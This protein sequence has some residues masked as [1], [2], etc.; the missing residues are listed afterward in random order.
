MRDRS[1]IARNISSLFLY[2]TCLLWPRTTGTFIP[3]SEGLN[4]ISSSE[5]WRMDD[6]CRCKAWRDFYRTAHPTR[7][8][9]RH[10]LE[11]TEQ[12]QALAASSYKVLRTLYSLSMLSPTPG[13]SSN[14]MPFLPMERITSWGDQRACSHI[15]NFKTSFPNTALQRLDLPPGLSETPTRG[16]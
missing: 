12:Y 8:H 1:N 16:W 3:L 11:P 10:P 7:K 14:F 6:H 2:V 13:T 4:F 9:D 15:T 5:L